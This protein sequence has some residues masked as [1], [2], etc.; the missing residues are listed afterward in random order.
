MFGQLIDP[1]T[2]KKKDLISYQ[3]VLHL[4]TLVDLL[5]MKEGRE[6]EERTETNDQQNE[7]PIMC[8]ESKQNPDG[9]TDSRPNFVYRQK[10]CEGQTSDCDNE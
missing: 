1:I 9:E 2:S 10:C 3:V 7:V 4:R 6:V 8:I 5:D